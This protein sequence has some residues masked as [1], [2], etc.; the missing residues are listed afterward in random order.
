MVM[1]LSQWDM[2]MF[3]FMKFIFDVFLG[4]FES[5]D[6]Y[7]LVGDLRGIGIECRLRRLWKI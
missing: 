4:N 2:L 1:L 6:Y 7:Y 3:L 5:K